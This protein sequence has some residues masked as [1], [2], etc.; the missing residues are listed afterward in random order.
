MT[1]HIKEIIGNIW[2]S[3]DIFQN[4][5]YICDEYGPRPSGSDSAKSTAIF[6][7]EKLKEYGLTPFT[8]KFE[9]PYWEI[10][11][12]VFN[13][14]DKPIRG[15][16]FHYS[17]NSELTEECYLLRN[18]SEES[19]NHANFKGKILIVEPTKKRHG[20]M[21]RKEMYKK[22]I[23]GGAV[24]FGQMSTERGGIIETGSISAKITEIPAFSISNEAGNFINRNQKRGKGNLALK[25]RGKVIQ[26]QAENIIG[27]MTGKSDNTVLL[28]AHYDTWDIGPGAF[29]NC[30]GMSTVL[31]ITEAISKSGLK[32]NLSSLLRV[33]F[34]SAEELGMLGSKA[35]VKDFIGTEN[36]EKIS[37]M[38]N[39]DCTSIKDG[40][41]GA[42]TSNNM[43]I[44]KHIEKFVGMY[45]FNVKMSLRPPVNTDGEPFFKRKIPTF[46]LAQFTSPSYMHTAFDTPDKISED[47]LKNSTAISGAILCDL[48]QKNVI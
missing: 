20:G 14:N 23:E 13:V 8:H 4:L 37:L 24:A 18:P 39:Y 22:A 12:A 7:T 30:T 42:F 3:S 48:M 45:G 25:I 29:D 6:L 16:P 27:D 10:E 46:G 38:M 41:R 32:N 36:E 1:N 31:G 19:F 17:K 2:E 47:E 11:E 33:V 21:S 28:G 15:I 44:H 5:I 34:F 43:K 40:V 9:H 35:Y 26:K